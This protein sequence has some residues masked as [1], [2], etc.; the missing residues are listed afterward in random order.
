MSYSI[1]NLSY[2]LIHFFIII[3]VQPSGIP[4]GPIDNDSISFDLVNVPVE[5]TL[6]TQF[7]IQLFVPPPSYKS[8]ANIHILFNLL[9]L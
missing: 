6:Y 7:N 1:I 3:I 8:V 9:Q 4:D 5:A 2:S